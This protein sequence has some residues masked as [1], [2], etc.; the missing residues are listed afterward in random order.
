MSGQG[1][2]E[3]GLQ[4]RVTEGYPLIPIRL[5]VCEMPELLKPIQYVDCSEKV[6]E[7]FEAKMTEVVNGIFGVELNP[8]A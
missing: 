6:G 1:E 4:K 5:D 7:E 3:A 8:Y 2:L